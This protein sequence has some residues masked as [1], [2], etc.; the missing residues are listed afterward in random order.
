MASGSGVLSKTAERAT[1]V[2]VA[3]RGRFDMRNAI[4]TVAVY[5]RLA[6]TPM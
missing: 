2:R 3:E 6:V 1:G 5:F 4:K